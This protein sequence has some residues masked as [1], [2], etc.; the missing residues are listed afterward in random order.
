[1]TAYELVAPLADAERDT[2]LAFAEA[3]LAPASEKLVL[4]ELSRLRALT[5]SRQ[6]GEDL[7]LIFSAFADEL[8]AYPADAVRSVLRGWRGKFW[9]SWGELADELDRIVG[10]RQALREALRR[11]YRESESA[12]AWSRPSEEEVA[13]VA[14]M[15]VDA[16]ISRAVAARASGRAVELPKM[17][18]ADREV[19]ASEL[20]QFRERWRAI[21]EV[22]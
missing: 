18:A 15:L 22:A 16:G 8:M 9:P 4:A 20:A 19:M 2:A 14:Q 10:P 7:A 21:T 13:R 6:A 11:G 12:P 17:T 1:M 3:I 5:A